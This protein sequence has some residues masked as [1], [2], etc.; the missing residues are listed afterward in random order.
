[1]D[2]RR[3]ASD[4]CPKNDPNSA[5]QG[6]QSGDRSKTSPVVISTGAMTRSVIG[7]VERSAFLTSL[8]ATFPK[9]NTGKQNLP[10]SP[11]RIARLE[12]DPPPNE[13][14]SNK[15]TASAVAFSFH[16][17]FTWTNLPISPLK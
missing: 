15:A 17:S 11:T 10:V 16:K 4:S 7:E 9:P 12:I 3:S 13:E 6:L 5:S 8:E 1:M 2:R 14:R